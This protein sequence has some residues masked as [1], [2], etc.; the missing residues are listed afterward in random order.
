MS[1]HVSMNYPISLCNQL[2]LIWIQALK[3]ADNTAA[4]SGLVGVR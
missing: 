3:K 1:H 4:R 2:G